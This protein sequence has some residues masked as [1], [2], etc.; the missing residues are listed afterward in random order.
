MEQ[1]QRKFPEIYEDAQEL[2]EQRRESGQ[3]HYRALA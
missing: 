2:A 1:V 3:V